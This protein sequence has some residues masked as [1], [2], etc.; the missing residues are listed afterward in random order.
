[1]IVFSRMENRS[2]DYPAPRRKSNA[3][4]TFSGELGDTAMI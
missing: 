1:M 2:D 4:V 3:V